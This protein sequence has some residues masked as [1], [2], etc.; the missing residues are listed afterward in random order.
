M[1]LPTLQLTEA[2]NICPDLRA[3][4]REHLAS[5]TEAQRAHIPS[6]VQEIVMASYTVPTTAP[7]SIVPPPQSPLT[8]TVAQPPPGVPMV[9]SIMPPSRED[10][11]RTLT[12]FHL[13][14]NLWPHYER[15]I[16]F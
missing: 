6:T 5:F 2:L 16:I 9:Q 13:L 15:L 7:P 4:L 11:V 14:K 10:M 12:E 3:P 1:Q 8:P